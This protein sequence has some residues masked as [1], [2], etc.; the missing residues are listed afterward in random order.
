MVFRGKTGYVSLQLNHTSVFP[1]DN[2]HTSVCSRCAFCT[3]HLVTEN[4]KKSS[5]KDQDLIKLVFSYLVKHIVKRKWHFRNLLWM[6]SR[7][8]RRDYYHH[9]VLLLRVVQRPEVVSTIAF[10]PSVSVSVQ[11]ERRNSF[12]PCISP[13]GS[14]GPRKSINCLWDWCS[15]GIRKILPEV[16]YDIEEGLLSKEIGN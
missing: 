6:C 14:S 13:K 1:W 3:S 12:G 11:R 16:R 5:L 2:H 4:I 7:E 9:V 10:A 8:K 15:K